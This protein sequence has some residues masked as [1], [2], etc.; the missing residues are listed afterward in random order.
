MAVVVSLKDGYYVLNE[1]T[2]EHK[3]EGRQAHQDEVLE[4]PVYK[5]SII[6]GKDTLMQIY[7]MFTEKLGNQLNVFHSDDYTVDVVEKGV[8]TP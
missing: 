7:Q 1:F 3:W 4:Q 5:F 6:A 2:G 8:V